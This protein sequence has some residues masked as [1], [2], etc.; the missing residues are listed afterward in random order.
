MWW[1]SCLGCVRDLELECVASGLQVSSLQFT[2]VHL[3]VSNNT[4][5]SA[6]GGNDIN[7]NSNEAFNSI[8]ELAGEAKVSVPD[9]GSV[10]LGSEMEV[11]LSFGSCISSEFPL[12]SASVVQNLGGND[13]KELVVER[14][15]LRK[16][17]WDWLV[18]VLNNAVHLEDS[19]IPT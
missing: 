3:R 15:S 13:F 4:A 18:H 17:T 5:E 16:H 7:G 19:I 9:G 12:E 6:G 11:M 10:N 1:S 8:N 14:W 2:E